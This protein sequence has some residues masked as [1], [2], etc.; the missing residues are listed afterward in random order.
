MR[1]NQKTNEMT[2]RNP[3]AV[4]IIE[5][6]NLLSSIKYDNR[7]GPV[8]NPRRVATLAVDT[9]NPDGTSNARS[10]M[11]YGVTKVMDALKSAVPT[12]NATS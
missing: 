7:Y 10:A 12:A 9:P 8:E 3:N 1:E 2:I 11:K 6:R 4:R 5:G